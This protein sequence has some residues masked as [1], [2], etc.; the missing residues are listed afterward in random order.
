MFINILVILAAAVAIAMMAHASMRA[1]QNAEQKAEKAKITREEERTA[2]LAAEKRDTPEPTHQEIS[3]PA[4][5]FR[6]SWVK[7]HA[8]APG[9]EVALTV[10]KGNAV[11]WEDNLA[12]PGHAGVNDEGACIVV[13]QGSKQGQSGVRIYDP[14]GDLMM[15]VGFRSGISEFGFT[16][17]QKFAWCAVSPVVGATA[18]RGRIMMFGMPDCDR[19]VAFPDV[20][21][22]HT[23]LAGRIKD[24]RLSDFHATLI[25]GD[26]KEITCDLHGHVVG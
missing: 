11:V 25:L 12:R 17:N 9:D 14:H 5:K 23:E 20:R 26:G 18:K 21:T 19:V 1:R 16:G 2:R 13:L 24:I 4:G 15:D 22:L 6:V 10:L 3:S 7:K 8:P